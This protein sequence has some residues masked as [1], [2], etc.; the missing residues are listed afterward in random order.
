[1]HH[2]QSTDYICDC[3]FFSVNS[4]DITRSAL[5]NAKYIIGQ[6]NPQVPRTFGDGTIHMSHLNCMVQVDDP[7]HERLPSKASDIEQVIGRVI[8]ENLVENGATLQMGNSIVISIKIEI[9]QC[10]HTIYVR[11]TGIGSIPDSVLSSLSGHRDLGIHS[12]MFSDGVVSLVEAGCVTNSKKKIL[13]GKIVSS[14]CIGSRRLYDFLDDNP[15]IGNSV[16]RSPSI[17]I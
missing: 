1:M 14:F 11:R 17:T 10:I 13:P 8:A 16:H 4:I 5:K 9:I 3:I 12:E 6:I 15:F 7:L 2:D